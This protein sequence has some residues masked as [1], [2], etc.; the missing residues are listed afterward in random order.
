MIPP[1][2]YAGFSKVSVAQ[3][4]VDIFYTTYMFPPT[5]INVILS[6]HLLA[7]QILFQYRAEYGQ[8]QEVCDPS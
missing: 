1:L 7:I 3:L 6:N 8:G 4:G 2:I 5:L